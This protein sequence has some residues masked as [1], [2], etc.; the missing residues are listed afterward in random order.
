MDGRKILRFSGVL[1][2]LI[3][4]L[5]IIRLSLEAFEEAKVRSA[6]IEVELV[7]NLDVAFDSDVNLSSLIESINGEVDDDFK[8]DTGKLGEGEVTFKY[9]NDDG[10]GVS[11]SFK[12]N[13]VD[14]VAPL[15]MLGNDYYVTTSFSGRL[16]EKILCAD[17]T[18]DEPYCKVEGTYDIKKPGNYNLR[19]VARDKAGNETVK[20]FVLHVSKPS[21]TSGNSYTLP[22]V[23][24]ND[25]K[26]RFKDVDAVLGVDVSSWQGDIDFAK[27]KEAGIEFAMVRV[28]SKWGR[29]KD[30]FLDSKFERNMKGFNEVGIPVGAYFYSYAQNAKEAEEE[31]EWLVDKLQDYDVDLP[32]A[33]DF[34]DWSNYNSY[35]MSIYRLNENYRAFLNV[36]EKAGYEGM[37]YSSVNYINRMWKLENKRV[38]VAH[39]TSKADY[40]GSY[41][42][43]QFSSAGRVDGIPADVDLNVWYKK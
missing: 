7:D 26:E 34:E 25:A 35:K 40:S 1:C 30:F 5:G 13:V 33:F 6:V 41:D 27:V 31:A 23:T 3:V 20:P 39:Y 2:L 11:Y 29:D 15:V 22:R 37:L 9:T 28:G 43:W 8:I 10:I 42:F 12:I 14:E 38:W 17:D 36:L 18:D 19:F 32:I 16:E 4:I 24:L 21:S